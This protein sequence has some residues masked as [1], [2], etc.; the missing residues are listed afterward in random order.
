MPDTIKLIDGLG[1]VVEFKDDEKEHNVFG[2][3]TDG[4]PYNLQNCQRRKDDL[5]VGIRVAAMHIYN[6][7]EKYVDELTDPSNTFISIEFDDNGV[8]YVSV[9]KSEHVVTPDH[10]ENK[11]DIKQMW[12]EEDC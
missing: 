4:K 8:P 2:F 11:L 1:R 12:R 9:N 3:D 6:R 5:I 10:V 7:A